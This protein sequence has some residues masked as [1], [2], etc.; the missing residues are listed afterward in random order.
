VTLTAS[1]RRWLLGALLVTAVILTYAPAWRAGFIWDDDKYVTQNELLTTPD[2]LK[3]IWFSLDS[4]SQYFPLVYTSFRLERAFWGLN[5]APYHLTNIFLH[6]I[7]ALLVWRLL[8]RLRVP[9][10][11]FAAALFALHPVQV[12]SVAWVTERKNMLVCL[13]SL[14]SAWAWLEFSGIGEGADVGSRRREEA[15]TNSLEASASS[16]RRLLLYLLSL[17]LFALALFSKTTACTLPLAFVLLEW[18][19]RNRI[20]WPRFAQI[21]PFLL[22]AIAMGLVTIWWE[23]HHQGVKGKLEGISYLD[24]FLIAN[25]AIWFYLGKLVWPG[26]LSFNY[27]LWKITPANPAAWIWPVLTVVV[28]LVLF[29]P[30]LPLRKESRALNRGAITAA[31]FYVLTLSPLLGFFMLATFKY[32]YVADHYQYVAAIGPFALAAVAINRALESIGKEN[33]VA[34]PIGLGL[35][36]L[37][38]AV[39]SFNQSATYASS[40]TLWRATIQHNPDSFLAHN[41]IAVDLEAKRQLDEAITHYRKAFDLQPDAL[42]GLNLGNAL[43]RVQQPD[44]AILYYTKAL[45]LQSNAPSILFRLGDAL[46]LKGEL[47]NAILNYRKALALQT[48][49]AAIHTHL[50]TAL[51]RK[52]RITEAVAEYEKA[53]QFEPSN[54]VALNNLAR[55]LSASPDDSVRNGDRAVALAQKAVELSGGNSP[56]FLGTLAISYANVGR[57]SDAIAAAQKALQLP[58]LN[59]AT[60]RSLK[61]E[62]DLYQSG[63]PF[64]DPTLANSGP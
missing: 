12:E 51:I 36:L 13:F 11:W 7:N 43:L 31:G 14:L 4:P 53:I 45:E 60:A 25:Q 1:S 18:W 56:G 5:P 24:R 26:N 33:P 23:Q 10:C 49:S 29:F 34:K 35:L 48:N 38:L 57:F 27:P 54:L 63:M 52:G 40:E 42:T 44:D 39:L 30:L 3:R 41:N 9:G 21:L 2:G 28:S 17:F 58:K 8:A 15:D 22:M 64:R 59:P 50:A 16:R 20:P 19:K 32:S 61:T 55:V 62:L 6:A 47:D 37:V 46:A